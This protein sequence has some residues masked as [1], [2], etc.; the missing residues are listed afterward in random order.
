MKHLNSQIIFKFE[1]YTRTEVIVW[2]TLS[3]SLSTRYT[4]LQISH[5]ALCVHSTHCESPGVLHTFPF[6][7]MKRWNTV[8]L[9]PLWLQ[10][11]SNCSDP[12][13]SHIFEDMDDMIVQSWKSMRS[14]QTE[15]P[16]TVVIFWQI[17]EPAA[18]E[19]PPPFK[20]GGADSSFIARKT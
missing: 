3:V 1:V 12:K 14:S 19:R 11:F 9:Q 8:T 10:Y 17:E 2:K 7:K 18:E 13:W 15:M 20:F 16:W 6:I 5:T 4:C